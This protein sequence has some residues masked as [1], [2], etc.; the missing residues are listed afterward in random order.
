DDALADPE[1]VTVIARSTGKAKAANRFMTSS[2]GC[3][4]APSVGRREPYIVNAARPS[5]EDPAAPQLLQQSK[6]QLAAELIQ[7]DAH[8]VTMVRHSGRKAGVRRAGR[9]RAA[10]RTPSKRPTR[11]N[12]RVG[13]YVDGDAHPQ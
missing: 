8:G 2:A 13:P 12:N 10:T 4:F 5:C 6:P 7:S 3:A 9:L 1:R 11:G